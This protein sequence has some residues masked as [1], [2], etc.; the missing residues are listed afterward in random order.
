MDS[1]AE[2]NL[3]GNC[4]KNCPNNSIRITPRVP[5]KE[6]WF[7][8]KP[9][10]EVSFLATVIMGIVFVQNI[11]MLKIW[12]G[13]L[14]QLENIIGTSNYYIT[15]TITFIIAMLIPISLLTLTGLIAKKFNGASV[16]DNFAKFGY[17]IIPL[18]MAGHI[19]HNL[20]HI[21]AEGKSVIFTLMGVFGM[22]IPNT[23][24]A[25]IDSPTIQVLQYLLIIL[26]TIGSIFTAYKI[27][28]N[29]Q[30]KGNPI[31]TSIVYAV[32]ML[33]LAVANILLFSLPMAMRM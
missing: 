8:K 27:A 16:K 31:A 22:N 1:S 32:L 5:T 3:C 30:S 6:L 20:F 13:I 14:K 29:S 4:V 21:L 26:G 33:I 15:F 9:K 24:T 11:T 10:L 23:S 17:S 2:C 18:D 25:F 28:K 19:A 12:D 7:I